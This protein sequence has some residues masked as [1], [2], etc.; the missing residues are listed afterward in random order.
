MDKKRARTTLDS[1]ALGLTLLGG[2]ARLVPHPPNFTPVGGMSLFAGSRLRGWQAYLV[3][4]LLM[5]ATD[6]ILS[7]TM[8]FPAYSRVSLFVYGSF[9]VN[10]WIGRR[11]L[12]TPTTRR[13]LGA[14]CLSSLQFFLVTNAGAWLVEGMY[15][16]TLAGLLAAYVA[17][18]PFYGR[19]LASDL[20]YSGVLFSLHAWMRRLP[21]FAGALPARNEIR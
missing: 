9:L 7:A 11:W 5:L 21:R 20:L 19:T 2:L 13:L 8:G 18:I 16:H 10:V 6:P 4:L 15:P 12:Q 1:L 3:P 17:A 14:A